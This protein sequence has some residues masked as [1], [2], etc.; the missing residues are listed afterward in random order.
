MSVFYV[1]LR[2]LFKPDSLLKKKRS[3]LTEHYYVV[4]RMHHLL[5]SEEPN[6]RLCDLLSI[7][8]TTTS[9]VLNARGE[10]DV[11]RKIPKSPLTDILQHPV[12]MLQLYSRLQIGLTNAWNEFKSKYDPYVGKTATANGSEAST[13]ATTSTSFPPNDDPKAETFPIQTLPQLF[14]SLLISYVSIANDF[15]KGFYAT[16]H[17]PMIKFKFLNGL[18]NREVK[19]RNISW[20][21]IW[22]S[23]KSTL[24]PSRIAKV[25]F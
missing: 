15:Y 24:D 1:G 14:A 19:K 25:Y 18:I 22:N 2:K 20:E 8:S 12:Y 13:S 6:L 23:M 10:L 11:D 21:V 17:H 4:V 9:S 7:D 16:K 3:L 5:I